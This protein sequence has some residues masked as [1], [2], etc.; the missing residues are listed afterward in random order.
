MQEQLTD[1]LVPTQEVETTEHAETESTESPVTEMTLMESLVAKR[2]GFFTVKMS[3]ADV[4]WVKNAC[5]DKF[6]F[7]GPNEAFMV[8]NCFLGFSGAT[9]RLKDSK[10]VDTSQEIQLQAS[11]VEGAAI[12][13]SR[14][15]GNGMEAAQRV[16]RIA[17]ALNGP[18]M[19]MKELDRE[20]NALK[21]E[22]QTKVK[23]VETLA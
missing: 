12:L 15:E 16:F 14:Y 6:T 8:M 9:A 10:E 20:I 18:A 17:V 21:L 22:E 7:T 11:A 23:P 3:P 5:N 1:Q 19:E 2:T 4:K 13:L